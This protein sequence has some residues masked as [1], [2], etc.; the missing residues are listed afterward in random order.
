[1]RRLILILGTMCLGLILSAQPGIVRTRPANASDG[2]ILTMEETILSRELTPKWHFHQ[3]DEK[4]V[5]FPKAINKGQS[6]FLVKAAGDTV[7]V[8][9][10]ENAH[11]TYGQVE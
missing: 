10:S 11:I 7:C 4:Q 5:A 3:W 8:A 9:E 2:K 6:L 1:M